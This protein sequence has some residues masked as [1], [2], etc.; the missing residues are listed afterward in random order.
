MSAEPSHRFLQPLLD[1]MKTVINLTGATASACYSELP[2]YKSYVTWRIAFWRDLPQNAAATRDLREAAALRDAIWF[3]SLAASAGSDA[4]RQLVVEAVNAMNS[5][6]SKRLAAIVAHPPMSIYMLLYALALLAAWFAGFGMSRE[7]KLA[8]MHVCAF[9]AM[10]AVM[11]YLTLDLE[12]P[13]YGLIR[14]S[15]AESLMT[16]LLAQMQQSSR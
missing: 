11:L 7:P 3:R 2:Q 13:R 1:P 9:A 12:Y 16:E 10:T 8:T 5:I 14:L 6:S 4:T 15:S